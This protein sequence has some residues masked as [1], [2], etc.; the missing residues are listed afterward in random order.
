[1]EFPRVFIN[2]SGPRSEIGLKTFTEIGETGKALGHQMALSGI[3]RRVQ[4]GDRMQGIEMGGNPIAE[5]AQESFKETPDYNVGLIPKSR[6]EIS[7][8]EGKINVEIVV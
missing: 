8:K 6:P 2:S 1:M 7:V 5:I 4:E 3:A